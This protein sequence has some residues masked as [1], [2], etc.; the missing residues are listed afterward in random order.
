[1]RTDHT[2]VA[3]TSTE[4]VLREIG[5]YAVD[6]GYAEGGYVEAV[7]N[8]ESTYPT[9]LSIPAE[10]FGIAIPHADPEHVLEEAVVLGLPEEPVAFRS[11]DDPDQSVDVEAVLLLLTEGSDGYAAFLS[12]LANLFQGDAF[13]D[14]VRTGDAQAVLELVDERCL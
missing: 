11:M 3:G 13:V 9:G 8:R 7:L 2:T 1:M 10:S 14:V 5:E 6:R 4:E 12:N